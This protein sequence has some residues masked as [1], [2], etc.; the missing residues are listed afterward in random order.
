MSQQK[1]K[2]AES[3]SRKKPPGWLF[4]DIGWLLPYINM[5]QPQV[6]LVGENPPANSGDK[7]DTGS[8]PV[9][10]RSPEGGRHVR[11]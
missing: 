10:G 7:R 4:Y 9:S 3:L 1:E 8:I 2:E 6:T 11:M 5:N